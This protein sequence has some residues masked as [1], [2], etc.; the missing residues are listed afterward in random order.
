MPRSFSYVFWPQA[1]KEWLDRRGI[2]ESQ[3][4]TLL[5]VHGNTINSVLNGS[6]PSCDLLL[7]ISNLL[8]VHPG[9]FFRKFYGVMLDGKRK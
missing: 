9:K 7:R 5:G 6:Y 1:I 3:L 4:P 8:E 2:A